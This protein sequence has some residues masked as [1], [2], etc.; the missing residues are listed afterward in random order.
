MLADHTPAAVTGTRP[1]ELRIQAEG[2]VDDALAAELG[3]LSTQRVTG[4]AVLTGTVVDAAEFW[5]VLHRLHRA[6]VKL[7]SV[8]RL[9]PG[10]APHHPT[11]GPARGAGC[12]AGGSGDV[13]VRIEVEGHAAGVMSVVL[14]DA[15]VYQTPPSTTLVMRVAGEDVLFS[16]LDLLED[17]ALDL[18]GIH[19]AG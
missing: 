4:G 13:E 15:D 19:V 17:L 7:R 6:G 18:R 5:G 9:G 10:G 11:A 8:E 1:L 3:G 2:E 14:A 12:P 16:V